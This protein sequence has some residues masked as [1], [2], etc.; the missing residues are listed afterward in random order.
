MGDTMSLQGGLL[1][2]ALLLIGAGPAATAPQVLGLAESGGPLPLYCDEGG[3]RAHLT[4]FCLQRERSM[5]DYGTAYTP[6]AGT[7]ITL[8]ATL[9]SGQVRLPGEAYLRFSAYRHFT[10]VTAL[11]PPETAARLGAI[12]F[13]VEVGPLAALVPAEE[14]ADPDPQTPEEIQ[15]AAGPIRAAAARFFD[16]SGPEA[17]AVRLTNALINALPDRGVRLDD[18]H[19]GVWQRTVDEAGADPAGVAMARRSYEGCRLQF[20][21]R[22]CLELLHSDIVARANRAYWKGAGGS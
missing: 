1:G 5:P 17:D 13:A 19:A 18:D 3:C 15:L 14:A 21:L 22:R 7:R 10:A 2:A 12:A 20:G 11:L 9:P 6:A 8:I 16:A 4:A